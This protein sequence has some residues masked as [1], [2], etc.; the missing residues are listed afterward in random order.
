MNGEDG[1]AAATSSDEVASGSPQRSSSSLL[2]SQNSPSLPADGDWLE[3]EDLDADRWV[4][5]QDID[6]MWGEAAVPASR[7]NRVSNLQSFPDSANLDTHAFH[8]TQPPAVDFNMQSRLGKPEEDNI[9][10]SEPSPNRARLS[11]SPSP[12]KSSPHTHHTVIPV[13]LSPDLPDLALSSPHPSK[14]ETLFTDA[15][16]GS[17]VDSEDDTG[18][19]G[20]VSASLRQLHAASTDNAS[21]PHSEG[22]AGSASGDDMLGSQE[23]QASSHDYGTDNGSE[24]S[25]GFDGAPVHICVNCTNR[26]YVGDVICLVSTQVF[27]SSVMCA[28]CAE[29]LD[30][31]A[32]IPCF[33]IC[34]HICSDTCIN[35]YGRAPCLVSAL[36][37][38]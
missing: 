3:A 30:V 16:P 25:D 20:D 1:M 14:E 28:S 35:M 10:S 8:A 11:N 33:E 21:S 12:F 27:F 18:S 26:M 24:S 6:N 19:S 17:I 29:L 4:K 15:A 13:K 22:M 9:E 37:L 31:H 23:D 7:S 2:L 32:V 34:W 36:C 38:L 5:A